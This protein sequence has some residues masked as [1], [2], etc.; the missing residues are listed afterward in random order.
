MNMNKT[1][2]SD[3]PM[4]EVSKHYEKFIKGKQLHPDGEK[5]FNRT[6]KKATEKRSAK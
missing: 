6:V 5:R 2:K 1:K 4:T 3:K